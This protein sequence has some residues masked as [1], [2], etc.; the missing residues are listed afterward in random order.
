MSKISTATAGV[1]KTFSDRVNQGIAQSHCLEEVAQ[2]F[3][4]SM[5]EEF[6]D[7][8]VLVRLFAAVPFQDLPE[9]IQTF[10]KELAASK[11]I[12]PLLR[13]DTLVLT[14]LGTRGANS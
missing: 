13:A 9:S 12:L 5:Y 7:S 3:T 6:K 4:D 11:E 2:A 10:V 8:I 14:L 1:L